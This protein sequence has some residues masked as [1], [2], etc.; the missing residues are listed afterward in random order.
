MR[1]QDRDYRGVNDEIFAMENRLRMLHDDKARSEHDNRERLNRNADEISD[2]RKQLEDLKFLLS[3]KTKQNLD[4]NDEL[5]R[6]K[7][8]LDEKYFEAGRLRDEAVNKGD[9]NADARAQLQDVEREIES[10]KVQRA[11]MWREIT[12]L[13]EANDARGRESADQQDKLKGLD[14]EN[15]RTQCRIEDTQKL[16]DA[17][18][19]DLRA[20]Q[21][22]LEDTERELARI[23]AENARISGENA[24]L[25]RDNERVAGENYD[26][27]KEVDF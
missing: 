5:S 4:L 3:D 15:Q 16:L 19:S 26:L 23:R 22:A 17:R 2:A 11:D 27:R 1:N 13:K 12:R 21:M 18:S 6:S 9:Q 24:A 20:K 8:L 25:T 7:R 10:V 14:F